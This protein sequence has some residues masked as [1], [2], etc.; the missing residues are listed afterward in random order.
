MKT[1]KRA[2]IAA[3]P[4]VVIYLKV[5]GALMVLLLLTIG[6]AHFDLG[7]WSVAVALLI[8]GVKALLILLFFMH[9]RYD[10]RE[11]LVFAGAAY[12]WLMI[13]IIGTLHDYLSRN[14]L[15]RL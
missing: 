2:S 9:L 1:D 8:A 12:L 13:L 15:P 3:H 14:W 4:S 10:R 5:W 7:D 11:V 6:I